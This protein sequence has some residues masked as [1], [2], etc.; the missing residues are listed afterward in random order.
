MRNRSL[1]DLLT[2]T[3]AIVL[4]ITVLSAVGAAVFTSL[5]GALGWVLRVE[6]MPIGLL[7]ATTSGAIG[8]FLMGTLWAIDRIVNRRYYLSP[9]RE[10]FQR[11]AAPSEDGKS[12][13]KKRPS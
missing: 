13:Q 5:C 10:G 1:L 12:L 7:W 9:S 6:R 2:W 8:G 3:G 4:A 11:P